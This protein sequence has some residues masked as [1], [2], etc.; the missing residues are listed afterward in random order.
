LAFLIREALLS[1]ASDGSLAVSAVSISTFAWLNNSSSDLALVSSHSHGAGALNS[2][3]WWNIAVSSLW[4]VALTLEA[5][6]V[7]LSV[8]AV[9]AVSSLANAWLLNGV[10]SAPSSSAFQWIASA[11]LSGLAGN[12]V[13]E[14]GL[15]WNVDSAS[16]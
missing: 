5:V 13:T 6:N 11:H 3:A 14:W 1:K 15:S 10:L 2:K 9:L 4:S 8:S 16:L 7:L 12:F